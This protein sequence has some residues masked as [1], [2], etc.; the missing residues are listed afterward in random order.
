VPRDEKEAPKDEYEQA[1]T[2]STRQ[3]VATTAAKPE[4]ETNHLPSNIDPKIIRWF[5]YVQFFANLFVNIDMGILPAGSTRIK[6]EIG[7]ENTEFGALG[8][9]VYLG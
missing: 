9:V 1:Q 6:E 3:S 5:L 7:L 4:F 8:S 2:H